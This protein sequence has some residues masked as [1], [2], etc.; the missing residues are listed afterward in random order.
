MFPQPLL[1]SSTLRHSDRQSRKLVGFLLWKPIQS[2]GSLGGWLAHQPGA[3]PCSELL[4]HS[5]SYNFT[6]SALCFYY[7]MQ[8]IVAA[9]AEITRFYV[10]AVP[11]SELRCH[12]PGHM[13]RL[14]PLGRSHFS[15]GCCAICSA[16]VDRRNQAAPSAMALPRPA[17][18]GGDGKD[19][20]ASLNLFYSFPPG[21]GSNLG[22]LLST[23][24]LP[25]AF[26]RWW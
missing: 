7:P 5:E 6:A 2:S 14:Q 22:N 23:H 9:A 10:M 24:S 18:H 15:Q 4:S 1:A 11:S 12:V 20:A 21:K 19:G 25:P 8:T 16:L 26:S 13:P 17:K 3:S